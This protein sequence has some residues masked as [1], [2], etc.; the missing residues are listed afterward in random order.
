[1]RRQEDIDDFFLV[2][3]N[4]EGANL[5]VL[6]HFDMQMIRFSVDGNAPQENF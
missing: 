1:M 2:A 5:Q 4:A 6:N 3:E